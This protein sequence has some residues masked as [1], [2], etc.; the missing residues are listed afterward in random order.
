MAVFKCKMCGG[1]LEINENRTVAEC[2]YCGTVQTVP[3]ADDDKKMSLFSRANRLRANNEFDKASTVYESIVAEFSEEAEAYWGLV[4][5]KYGIEYVDDPATGKKI[6]TCHRSSFE[7]V[8]DDNN[9][10]LTLEYADT[11]AKRVYREEAKQIEEIRKGIIEVSSKEEPY[12]IFICYK[13]TAE[14]GDRTIDSVL[15]QDIYE[16]VTEKGYRTFFAKITLED[17]LGQEYEPYIFAALTSAKIMLVVGTDYEYFDA[18]WV[19]NEWSRFLKLMVGDK[20]KHLIPCYKNID[21]YDMP[22]EFAKL[23]AQDLGKVGAMQDLLRGIEKILPKKKAEV[24]KE[25]VKETVVTRNG[26]DTESLLKRA[27]MFLEDGDWDSANE[28]CEKVLDIDPENAQAYLGKLMA[29]VKVKMQSQ[30]KNCKEP[31]DGS[32][33]YKKTLRFADNKLKNEL[34]ECTVYIKNRNELAHLDGIYNRAFNMMNQSNGTEYSFKEAA[35][36]FDSISAYK[37]SASLIERCYKKAEAARKDEILHKAK[38]K[39]QSSKSASEYE[40]AIQLLQTIPGWQ[41]AEKNIDICRAKIRKLKENELAAQ[42]KLKREQQEERERQRLIEEQEKKAERRKKIAKVIKWIIIFLIIAATIFVGFKW[43]KNK[44]PTIDGIKYKHTDDGYVVTGYEGSL[45]ELTIPSKVLGESVTSIASGAFS[46]CETIKSVVIP[47]SVVAINYRAFE[48][49]TSLNSI[50]IPDS[51][52]S[53]GGNAFF[54]CSNLVSIVIPNSVTSVGEGAFSECMKLMSLTIG[55][56]ESWINAAFE[57]CPI[58]D[59]TINTGV[60]AIE[61]G[62]FLGFNSLVNVTLPSG[63]TIIGKKAFDGC[64]NLTSIVIPDSVTSIGDYAFRNC[65]KLS[66]LTIGESVVEI[67]SCAFQHC[68]S[69]FEVKIP[70]SV[71]K[72]NSDAF[73]ECEN[74]KKIIFDDPYE[75]YYSGLGH[76]GAVDFSDPAEAADELVG[77]IIY[78]HR[79]YTK[80]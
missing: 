3:R 61:E 49:C 6:P 30:L 36:L 55:S 12:D 41:D 66:S 31:F 8:L 11:L 68:V 70:A 39:M 73:Y 54:G 67:G 29:E 59:L 20:S 50:F 33:N 22:K 45:T 60:D 34:T 38:L 7:S 10:E 47:D 17:K 9:Y 46:C 14:N 16:A 56:G 57:G 58:A 40:S 26:P 5:S 43:Y 75:W 51:V 24:V 35:C 21:A 48:K 28:Y 32:N 65:T 64:T 69:L 13:E 53:I 71:L 63:I 37:D 27:F 72:I 25:V 2:E 1:A 18:V 80:R 19:K 77:T 79:S 44:Y 4:L 62:T 42:E 52:T 76:S 74:V 78:S 23:Q 15:A